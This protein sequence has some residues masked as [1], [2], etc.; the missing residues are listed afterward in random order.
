MALLGCA[1]LPFGYGKLLLPHKHG[2]DGRHHCLPSL[3]ALFPEGCE[4]GAAAIHLCGTCRQM[5]P[6]P[7]HSPTQRQHM[8]AAGRYVS[9]AQN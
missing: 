6:V 7:C 9:W 4:A 8:P 5:L 1:A 3:S 2:G